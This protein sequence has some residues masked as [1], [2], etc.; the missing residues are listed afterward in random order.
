ME[1]LFMKNYNSKQ[2]WLPI[3]TGDYKAVDFVVGA[4]FNIRTE[5]QV[6]WLKY[7]CAMTAF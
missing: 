3:E 5:K 1:S 4:G 2:H 7:V 6:V